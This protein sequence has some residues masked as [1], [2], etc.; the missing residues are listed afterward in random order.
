MNAH[1]N[2]GP[3]IPVR[4][5]LYGVSGTVSSIFAI[6]ETALPVVC[7]INHGRNAWFVDLIC[8]YN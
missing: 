1:A 4:V 8:K 5:S 6:I 2:D 7:G 3:M